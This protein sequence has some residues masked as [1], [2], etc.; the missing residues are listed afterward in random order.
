M[1]QPDDGDD[2]DRNP[3]PP[4]HTDEEVA[5]AAQEAVKKADQIFKGKKK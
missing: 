5:D 1:T 3:N 4:E 2:P